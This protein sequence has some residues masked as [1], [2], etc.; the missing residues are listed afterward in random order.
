[1]LFGIRHVEG[2]RKVVR[3]N[4]DVGLGELK[5]FL[6][7]GERAKRAGGQVDSSVAKRRENR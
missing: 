4:R 2:L 6:G 3:R 7:A 1:V 5:E